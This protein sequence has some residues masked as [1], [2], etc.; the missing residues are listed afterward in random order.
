MECFPCRLH[1]SVTEITFPRFI[2]RSNNL[3]NR[4]AW[5]LVVV[6]RGGG[7]AV[8]N[9]IRIKAII[10]IIIIIIIIVVNYYKT[11]N[12]TQKPKPPDYGR[13]F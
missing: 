11:W 9:Y 7:F 10:I 12:Q 8:N 1:S 3:Y 13:E 4:S 6:Q 2:A 5:P